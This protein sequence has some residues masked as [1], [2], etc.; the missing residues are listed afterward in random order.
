MPIV[1]RRIYS[2]TKKEVGDNI[3]KLDIDLNN[4]LEMMVEASDKEERRRIKKNIYDIRD[5]QATWIA[6]FIKLKEADV[7]KKF[8][9][10]NDDFPSD[11]FV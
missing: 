7:V 3:I 8:T 9:R 11:M 2:T 10:K 4:Q 1:E 5:C 6:L